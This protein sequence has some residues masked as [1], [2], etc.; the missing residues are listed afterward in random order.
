MKS[1]KFAGERWNVL[2]SE[3]NKLLLALAYS[4]V[5]NY[6]L[7]DVAGRYVDVGGGLRDKDIPTYFSTGKY[8]L[9]FYA[10]VRDFLNVKL[11]NYL[12]TESQ[13][14]GIQ[15]IENMY[16]FCYTYKDELGYSK[17]GYKMEKM[18]DYMFCLREKDVRG[19]SSHEL[20]E[21]RNLEK[22]EKVLLFPS[23]MDSN[24]YIPTISYYSPWNERMRDR[25]CY[26]ICRQK[27]ETL[28]DDLV[29]QL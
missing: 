3:G 27:Y 16:P 7:Y 21:I 4:I 13:K 6:S 15:I 18:K 25:D 1:V 26:E 19:F 11:F 12:F 22:R 28:K 24:E 5:G 29:L 14:S 20:Y 9:S 2:K 23:S 17:T 10:N 8:P